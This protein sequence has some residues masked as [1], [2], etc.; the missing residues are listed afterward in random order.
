MIDGDGL[1]ELKLILLNDY[2]YCFVVS[3]LLIYFGGSSIYF[4]KGAIKPSK[5][6]LAGLE[7]RN[8]A[9]WVYILSF[10]SFWGF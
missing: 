3:F 8:G 1:L 5:P 9:S 7:R 4:G 6:V 2:F 10:G